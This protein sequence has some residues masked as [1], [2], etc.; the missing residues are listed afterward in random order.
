MQQNVRPACDSVSLVVTVSIR[1]AAH[2]LVLVKS[3]PIELQI[4]LLKL[5][6]SYLR[7]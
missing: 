7:R 6:E 4:A 2:A 5:Y 1:N 3:V